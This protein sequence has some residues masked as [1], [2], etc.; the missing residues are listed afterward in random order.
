LLSKQSGEAVEA[1]LPYAEDADPQVHYL[2]GDAYSHMR[3]D[4]KSRAHYRRFLAL[5]PNGPLADRVRSS[6]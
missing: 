1:L 3:D 2:L 5:R 6:S 4:E